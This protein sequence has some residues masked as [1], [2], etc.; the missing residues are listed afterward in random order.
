MK[1]IDEAV[2][3]IHHRFTSGDSEASPEW[4]RLEKTFIRDTILKAMR[5]TT[6]GQ[7]Q[8]LKK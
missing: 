8:E 3:T 5:A 7:L 4:V 1:A 6:Y 2:E